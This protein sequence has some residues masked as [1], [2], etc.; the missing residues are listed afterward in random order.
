[1]DTNFPIGP[2]PCGRCGGEY[3]EHDMLCPNA[4]PVL[5]KV[6]VD[7]AFVA[8]VRR[9]LDKADRYVSK[10]SAPDYFLEACEAVR[11]HLPETEARDARQNV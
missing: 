7:A 1:M 2:N 3:G 6:L 4:K 5:E 9:L 11:R 8:D 10:V